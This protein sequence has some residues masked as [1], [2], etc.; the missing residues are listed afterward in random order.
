MVGLS[1][2]QV[3]QKTKGDSITGQDRA[4]KL[5]DFRFSQIEKKSKDEVLQQGIDLFKRESYDKPEQVERKIS[6]EALAESRFENVHNLTIV[7]IHFLSFDI[8]VQT[9]SDSITSFLFIVS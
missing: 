1:R 7:L 6:P 2:K 3:F 8:I 4:Q 9:C 5:C